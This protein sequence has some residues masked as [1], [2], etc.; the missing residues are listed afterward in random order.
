MDE[1]VIKPAKRE[2]TTDQ[3][4]TNAEAPESNL[5]IHFVEEGVVDQ[6]GKSETSPGCKHEGSKL[7]NLNKATTND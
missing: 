1:D 7:H 5:R 6:E 4:N 3:S 2:D